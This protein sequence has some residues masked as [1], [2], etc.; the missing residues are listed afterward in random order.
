MKKSALSIFLMFLL[1]FTVVPLA[2][3][4]STS[5]VSVQ[6]TG[7]GTLSFSGNLIGGNPGV[8]GPEGIFKVTNSSGQVV[9]SEYRASSTSPGYFSFKVSNLPNDTYTIT[10]K[11]ETPHTSISFYQPSF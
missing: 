2:S 11:A 6:I 8:Y 10:G 5:D 7:Q 9:F 1:I 3:A 4:A